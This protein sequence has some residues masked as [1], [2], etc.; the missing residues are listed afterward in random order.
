MFIS[1]NGASVNNDKNATSLNKN[2]SAYEKSPNSRVRNEGR[3]APLGLESQRQ[4]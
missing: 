2:S 1:K 3:S 4:P